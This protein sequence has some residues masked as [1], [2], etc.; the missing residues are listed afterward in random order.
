MRDLQA[1]LF[2]SDLHLTP[3]Y[4]KIIEIFLYFLK[5]IAIRSDALYILGDFFEVYIGDD[6]TAVWLTKIKKALRKLTEGGVPIYVM[7]GNRDF[8]I[9]EKFAWASGI[10]LIP[11]PTVIHLADHN[12][13]LMHGDSL[14]TL[15]KRHQR[16]RQWTHCRLVQNL[17]LSLPK[18]IREKI[19]HT[20]RKKSI[21]RN[22]DSSDVT[23]DVNEYTVIDHM[24]KHNATILI[25]GHTHKP[26]I[27]ELRIH[28]KPTKRI[29]LD[30]WHE[31][32]NYLQYKQDGETKLIW[33]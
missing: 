19:A 5:N 28:D 22:T 30:A 14:C 12:I 13:L 6:D 2:I 24:K 16:F 27:H 31:S 10:I 29:V 17:F 8:L 4:P 7:H 11:D 32:G 20:I 15:D 33:M 26:E 1:T 3:H 9:R 23:M 25:H 21:R 18:K